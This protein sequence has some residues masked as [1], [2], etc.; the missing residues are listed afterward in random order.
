MT[1]VLNVDTIAAKNGT[2]PVVLTKQVAP[3]AVFGMNMSS[4]TFATVT[5]DS[6]P[7]ATLNIA[8]AVDAGQ[9]DAHGNYTNN[10]SSLQNVY[11]DGA[12]AANNTMN[13]DIGV[14]TTAL[15]ATQQHDAD[16]SSD[17][18]TYGFTLVFGDLA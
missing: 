8:S 9:G 13:V 15:L 6:I 11:P 3:K 17:V 18:D 4:S 14:T 10:M 7:S 1:S 5:T 16:S 12:I 2:S